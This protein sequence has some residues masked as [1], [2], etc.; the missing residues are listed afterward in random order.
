MMRATAI[1]MVSIVAL[2]FGSQTVEA[3]TLCSGASANLKCLKL[4][5]EQLATEDYDRFG[6]I[7]KKSSDEAKQCRSIKKTAEFLDLARIKIR[8]AEFEEFFAQATESLCVS[9]PRCFKRASKLLDKEAQKNLA[10]M[11][12]N[13]LF[14]DRENLRKAGCLRRTN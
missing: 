5:F 14:V 2:A 13:P 7:L 8:G 6:A 11:L 3:T 9:S 1:F 12:D 4:H 10:A